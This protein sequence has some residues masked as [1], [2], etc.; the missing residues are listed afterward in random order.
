MLIKQ[1]VDNFF[2]VSR[3]F[4]TADSA[5]LFSLRQ[6]YGEIFV[7][8][9]KCT[10]HFVCIWVISNK[11]THHLP[12]PKDIRHRVYERFYGFQTMQKQV[13]SPQKCISAKD[14][15]AP[16]RMTPTAHRLILLKKCSRKQRKQAT[17]E[18]G[19]RYD[20]LA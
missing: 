16:D 14:K 9:R 17:S 1:L 5:C 11:I 3:T 13:I 4:T 10:L 18:R 19:E 8:I 20:E 2:I 7:F 12:A 15:K 6:K